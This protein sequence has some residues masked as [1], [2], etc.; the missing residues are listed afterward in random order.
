[1]KPDISI[2]FPAYN[3]E[4]NLPKLVSNATKLMRDIANKYEIIL[5]VYEKST[6]ATVKLSQQYAKKD[7]NIKVIV[8]KANYGGVGRGYYLGFTNAKYPLVMF[9][10]SDNQFNLQDL[11]KLLKHIPK[12]DIVTGYRKNRADPLPRIIA[13]N[14][15]N[16]ILNLIFNIGVRDADCAL[17]I[18]KKELINR[19]ELNSI[20]GLICPELM[21]KS[22]RLGYSIKEIP[23]RHYQRYANI[24]HYDRAGFLQMRVI[25]FAL[26]EIWNVRKDLQ[27]NNYDRQKKKRATQ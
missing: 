5:V 27:K 21:I 9:S 17:K 6:D 18:I 25:G 3:E 15:Y 19:I 2:F 4:D 13:A 7:K 10:D 26:K 11:K 23:V 14:V 1:M 22:K 12:Y 16:V 20:S 24:P 8:Q